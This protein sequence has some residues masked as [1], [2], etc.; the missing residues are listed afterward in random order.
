VPG[1]LMAD[2]TGQ[3]MKK[4]DIADRL[5]ISIDVSS[6]QELV[7][8]CHKINNMVST[9]KLGLEMFYNC[10]PGIVRTAKSFGYKVMLD[11]KLHDIPN[12]VSKAASSITRLGVEKI[13]IHTSGGIRM[14]KDAVGSIA[15]EAENMNVFP[16]LLF[17]V[18]V[19][20]SLDDSDLKK[21][22]YRGN[23][24]DTVLNLAGIA[25]ESGLDGLVCSPMEVKNIKDSFGDDLMIATPGIR[26]ADDDHDDQ[27]RF[28][29]PHSAIKNGADYVIA[30]R[31]V[32]AKKDTVAAIKKIIKEIEEALQ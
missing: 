9:L 8:L 6:R 4:I 19:L 30:G 28:S 10:G 21:I 26:L 27:K 14:L 31:S 32:T 5:I 24:D 7:F 15:A 1:K 12:T 29:T 25:V 11:A 20:T 18:T 3:K 23:H 22:G 16:P 2:I 13:T 17:G